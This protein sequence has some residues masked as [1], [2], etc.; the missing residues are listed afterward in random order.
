[1]TYRFTL[2]SEE[3]PGGEL[4][5]VEIR[6]IDFEDAVFF[7]HVVPVQ[8]VLAVVNSA[9]RRYPFKRGDDE[10][11]QLAGAKHNVFFLEAV[12]RWVHSDARDFGHFMNEEGRTIHASVFD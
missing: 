9:D 3:L 2:F 10:A 11:E 1:V 6:L 5:G 4:T 7:N 12:T 8:F